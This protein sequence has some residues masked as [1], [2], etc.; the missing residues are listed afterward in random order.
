MQWP[1][2]S[3]YMQRSTRHRGFTLVEL[4]VVLGIIITLGRNHPLPAAAVSIWR[5][6]AKRAQCLSNL[7][8]LT[9]AWIGYAHDN[10]SH[11]CS[12]DLGLTWSW[13]G[14][15]HDHTLINGDALYPSCSLRTGFYGPI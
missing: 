8:Q 6:S 14:P 10:D 9:A 12:P 7:Q 13:S 5:K 4:L 11:F 15:T 3:S 2:M 1:Q